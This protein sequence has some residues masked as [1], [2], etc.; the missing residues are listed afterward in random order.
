[1]CM[2]FLTC[3]INSFRVVPSDPSQM[4][5][6]DLPSDL[7]SLSWLTSVDVPRLQQM[8][9]GR[10]E[11]S[12]NSQN[13]VIQQQGSLH[14]HCLCRFTVSMVVCVLFATS[15]MFSF[16]GQLSN[17]MPG[18]MIHIPASMQQGILGLNTMTSHVSNVSG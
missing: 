17:T 12:M 5:D 16:I 15:C 1:M 11:Y 2:L 7:Q 8:T 9:S 6:D 4:R 18:Q 10:M 14:V 13:I 3:S